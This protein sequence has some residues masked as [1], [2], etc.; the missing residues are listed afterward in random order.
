MVTGTGKNE[1]Y[2][3]FFL[4]VSK[5]RNKMEDGRNF[6]KDRNYGSYEIYPV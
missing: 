3:Y 5:H 1:K 6:L 4:R 2:V